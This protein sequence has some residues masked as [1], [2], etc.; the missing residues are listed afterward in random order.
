MN[1]HAGLTTADVLAVFTDESRHDGTV[2]DTFQDGHVYFTRSVLPRVEEARPGDQLQGGVA[3]KANEAGV[4]LHPYV[5]RLVC[6][7]GAI[8][9]QA[10]RPG[11]S[12]TRT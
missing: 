6:R 12:W 11:T 2:T 3:L 9:A 5:L 8:V 7:N 1:W 4:W 10:T